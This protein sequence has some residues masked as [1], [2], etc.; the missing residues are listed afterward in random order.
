LAPLINVPADSELWFDVADI[1]LLRED[2]KDAAEITQIQAVSIGGLVRDGFTP[3]SAT[4]AVTSQ[5]MTLL[6]PIP[7]WVSVQLQQANPKTPAGGAP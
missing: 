3:E 1:P 7:G 5:N 6:Q 2:A 4:A